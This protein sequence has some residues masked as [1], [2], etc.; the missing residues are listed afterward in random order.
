MLGMLSLTDGRWAC[1]SHVSVADDASTCV[2]QELIMA[3]NCVCMAF[4]KSMQTSMYTAIS[5]R[6]ECR[7]GSKAFVLGAALSSVHG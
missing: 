1:V 4:D 6:T 2:Q 5:S 3:M 7:A